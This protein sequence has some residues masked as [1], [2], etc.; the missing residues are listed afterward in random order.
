MCKTISLVELYA[1][2]Q[3]EM[4]SKAEFSKVLSHP[5]D[6][7]DNTETSWISWFS[8]YL[9]NTMF[10]VFGAPG[11]AQTWSLSL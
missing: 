2:L 3:S 11:S 10:C 5:T 1:S 7:G 4:I 9:P 8:K 6:Q